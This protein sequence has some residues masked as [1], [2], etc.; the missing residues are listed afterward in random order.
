MYAFTFCIIAFYLYV[1]FKETD[2][3]KYF[4]LSTLS[5]GISVACKFDFLLFI[6]LIVYEL[7]KNKSFKDFLYCLFL[8]VAPLFC[9]YGIWFMTG[10]SIDGLIQYKDFLAIFT[11]APSVKIFNQNFL[12]QSFSEKT[13]GALTISFISFIFSI[14][15]L[16]CISGILILIVKKLKNMFLKIFS[17]AFVIL[18]GYNFVI[19]KIAYVQ[20]HT[21]NLHT[22]FVFVPYIVLISAIII[23]LLKIKEKKYSEKEKF[24]FITAI[25]AFLM[26]YRL[27][28]AVFISYIGN[29]IMVI[30]WLAFVYLLF[31]L[32][33]EYFPSL[34]TDFYKKLVSLTL[35]LYGLTYTLV[36]LSMTEKKSYRIN[37]TKGLFYTTSS[38]TVINSAISY[39][40]EKTNENDIILVAD[41]GLAINYFA[42]RQTNMKYYSLIPHMIDT[43]GDQNIISDLSKNLPDY[44]LITNNFYPYIGYF[45][46]NYAQNIL[47]FIFDK[48]DYVQSYKETSSS[49]G[50][51]ITIFK[52]K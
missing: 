49:K 31:E 2:N 45:G 13:V 21:L 43:Y 10:G 12:I 24:Y 38:A 8:F 18:V 15:K 4:Y 33:P 27:Y 14:F 29:F 19:T 34:K 51:E 11:K 48:Y 41:E 44:I 50:F 17:T 46:I 47:Q 5:A 25:V 20:I 26:S 32:L 3:K 22:N 7:I 36:Y 37:S 52:K 28:A 30:Y 35:V 9:S 6:L 16:L 40:K 42:D 1:L 23:F 39:I